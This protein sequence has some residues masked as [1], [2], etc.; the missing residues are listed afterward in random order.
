VKAPAAGVEHCNRRPVALDEQAVPD[1]DLVSPRHRDE[2][3]HRPTANHP[4]EM[5]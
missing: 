1:R 5:V 4:V 2:R 3:H